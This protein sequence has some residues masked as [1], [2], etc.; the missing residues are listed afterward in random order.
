MPYDSHKSFYSKAVL[1]LDGDAIMLR[2]YNTI[3]ASFSTLNGLKING[4]YSMTTRRH[5]RAFIEYLIRDGKI[6]R[7]AVDGMTIAKIYE[8]YRAKERD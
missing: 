1:I 2:S 6:E 5:L 8:R 3:V 4:L 7:D